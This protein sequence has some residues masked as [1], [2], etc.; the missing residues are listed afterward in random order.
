MLKPSELGFLNKLTFCCHYGTHTGH[1]LL[2]M[3]VSS[4][5]PKVNMARYDVLGVISQIIYT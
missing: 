3:L 1:T 4:D 2:R 5:D